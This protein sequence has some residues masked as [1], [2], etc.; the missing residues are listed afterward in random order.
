MET[1]LN[2]IMIYDM[3]YDIVFVPMAFES[4]GAIIQG[5]PLQ[6]FYDW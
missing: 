5:E 2:S 6:H 3:I 4:M 1:T